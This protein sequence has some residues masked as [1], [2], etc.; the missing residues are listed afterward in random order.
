MS[1]DFPTPGSPPINRADPGTNPPPQ[2]RSNSAS[3][4]G[5]AAALRR[6]FSNLQGQSDGLGLS[7]SGAAAHRR[8]T[9]FFDDGVPAA[10]GIAAPGPFV[11]AGPARLANER[12]LR[13]R[14]LLFLPL[15]HC[16]NRRRAAQT[17]SQKGP[18]FVAFTYPRKRLRLFRPCLKGRR[19]AGELDCQAQALTSILI[20]PSARPLMN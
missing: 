12:A 20:G 10:A 13:F 9:S 3:P 19:N 17:I 4:V 15:R 18:R 11:V 16:R 7:A 8:G 6:R 1:V 5:G 14:H 2:T